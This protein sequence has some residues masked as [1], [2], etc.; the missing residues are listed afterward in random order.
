[1]FHLQIV[2]FYK[3]MKLIDMRLTCENEK[4]FILDFILHYWQVFNPFSD[5]KLKYHLTLK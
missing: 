4:I 2:L 1:M 3:N 5:L